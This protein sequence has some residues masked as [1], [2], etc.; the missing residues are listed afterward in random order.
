MSVTELLG[1]AI[2]S[3][4]L[5]L[6]AAAIVAWSLS[7][8]RSDR[9]LLWFGLW[10]SLYGARLLIEQ[11]SVL[12][13]LGGSI[14]GWSYVHAFVTYAI[15]IPVGLFVEAL[16]GPG[17][18]R[19]VRWVWQA[20]AAYAVAAIATDLLLGRPR[21]AMALNS[22]IVLISVA[23]GLMNLWMFRS[24][25]SPTFRRRSIAAGAIVMLL[26]VINENLGRPIGPE[27]NLEPLGVFTFVV[28]LGAG[29]V[30]SVF[31]QE[32]ELVAIQREL[33]TARRIQTS[34]LPRTVPRAPG[35][36]LAVRY[37]P[38]TAVAGDLYDFVE[39]GPSQVGILVADVSGH[40][41]PA[42]L[43]ASMVKLAFAAQSDSAQNPAAVLTGMNK[44]LSRHAE[45]TFVTAV[46]AVVDTHARS[47]TVANAGH[48]PLLTGRADGSV[49]ESCE[50]GLMLGVVDHAQYVNGVVDLRHG[51]CILVYT[52]GVPETQSPRGDFLDLERV[53]E[54]LTQRNGHDA[55]QCAESMMRKLGDWRGGSAFED[56]VTLVVARF[57]APVPAAAATT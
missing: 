7:H 37:V 25:L 4:L 48:P 43:V 16:I 26:F 19:S 46:Y 33:E 17:W 22:S 54:W 29:V 57:E 11:P 53:R 52:D 24:R 5:S 12:E 38:M 31:R 40:G 47:I 44:I 27:I 21:A 49:E 2:G 56:D 3:T 10:C 35:V 18:K 41:V 45:G 36:D 8:R 55:A 1:S 42:A 23:L 14:R 39:P 30:G 34:L 15:N 20:Q 32:A 6:G 50:R 28:S 51:D 9:V 13:A